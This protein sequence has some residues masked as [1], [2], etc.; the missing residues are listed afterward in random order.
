MR[1]GAIYPNQSFYGDTSFKGKKLSAVLARVSAEIVWPFSNHLLGRVKANDFDK[2]LGRMEPVDLPLGQILYDPGTPL[3]HVY[4]PTSG[5]ISMV[6]VM[7]D[8]RAIEGATIGREGAAGISASGFVDPAFA[9][10]VVQIPGAGFRV[11]AADFE[12]M[13]DESVELCSSIARWRD[14]LMRMILQSVACNA[15]HN[16]R[17]RCARW[18]LTTHDRSETTHLALTQEFLAEMLGVK[19]NAVSI[20]AR[21]LQAMGA[22]EYSRGRLTVLDTNILASLSC[23]CHATLRREI[24]KLFDTRVSP[25][26]DD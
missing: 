1:S 11:A 14:L 5:M 4:F 18:I 19:R 6:V 7:A 10:Y 12:D 17:Q 8:G 25:E 23:E 3:T 15:L 9:R 24:N 13:I 16:V 26:C 2:M 22:I 21:E 20:V